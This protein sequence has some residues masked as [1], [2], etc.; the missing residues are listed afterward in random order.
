MADKGIHSGHR[1]RM[2]QRFLNY[3]AE[4]MY[5]HELLEI[6]LFY[7]RPVV[8]TNDTAHALI[9]SA[10][11][12]SAVLDA[13]ISALEDVKG[14]GRNSAVFIK[15]LREGVLRYL[16]RGH[17]DTK[18][19][20]FSTMQDFFL[21][22]F[23]GTDTELCCLA[24]VDSSMML[25]N[26]VCLPCDD[27]ASGSISQRDIAEMLILRSSYR[28]IIGLYRPCGKA[29]PVPRDYAITKMLCELTVHL[30]IELIDSVVCGSSDCYSMRNSG[31]FSFA[32]W[33][34]G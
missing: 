7:T 9:E 25:L 14:V 27:I 33:G 23:S 5:D 22:Y 8:N 20:T 31:S 6:A 17:E 1:Q 34:Y 16:S 13:D 3:P 15:I 29:V 2:K 19:D 32:G 21:S 11:S 4:F 28:L 26:T 12:V 30:G 24:T 10:G 18:L